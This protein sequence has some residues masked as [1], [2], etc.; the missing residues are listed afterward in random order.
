MHERARL[1]GGKL[2]IWSAPGSGTEVE[3]TIPGAI[4]YARPRVARGSLF[5][6]S[7]G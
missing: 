2:A 3:L 7:R 6:G 1:T 5:A 4:A